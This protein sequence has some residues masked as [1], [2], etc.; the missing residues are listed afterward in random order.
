[1]ELKESTKLSYSFWKR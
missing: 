1:M